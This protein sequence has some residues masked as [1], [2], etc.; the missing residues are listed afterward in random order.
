MVNEIE[1]LNLWRN[2]LHGSIPDWI[3][4]LNLLE[5][6]YLGEN[7]FSGELPIEISSKPCGAIFIRHT[8][9]GYASSNSKG[10]YPRASDRSHNCLILILQ[11]AR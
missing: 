4:S 1:E 3:R 5:S 6:L 7:D 8:N 10:L 9:R 11:T 2:N